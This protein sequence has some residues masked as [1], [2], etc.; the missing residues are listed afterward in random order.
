[1]KPRLKLQKN[2]LEINKLYLKKTYIAAFLHG[3]YK[4]DALF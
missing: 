4:Q 2:Y 1:M 3:S